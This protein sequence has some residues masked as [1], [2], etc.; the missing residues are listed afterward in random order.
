MKF[1]VEFH[2]YV[3]ERTGKPKFTL[4]DLH[5]NFMDDDETH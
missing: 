2:N 3:N 4:Q 5:N 1:F